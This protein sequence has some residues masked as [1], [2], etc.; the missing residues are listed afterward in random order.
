MYV[1]IPQNFANLLI[2]LPPYL[3]TSWSLCFQTASSTPLAY[4]VPS[5]KCTPSY[6]VVPLILCTYLL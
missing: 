2:I 6:T 5:P 3:P 4:L 1:D